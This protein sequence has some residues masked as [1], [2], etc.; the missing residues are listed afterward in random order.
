MENIV[1]VKAE[2]KDASMLQA[3]TTVTDTS[4][5]VFDN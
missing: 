4:L 3:H 2:D 1:Y 5:T